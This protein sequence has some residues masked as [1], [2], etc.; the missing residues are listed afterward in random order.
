MTAMQAIKE[1][2]GVLGRFADSLVDLALP[3]A[4]AHAVCGYRLVYCFCDHH[5]AKCKRCRD[6][7]GQGSGCPSGNRCPI[8]CGSC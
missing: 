6:C 3:K 5:Q 8:N 7:T 2:V 1:R 4:S